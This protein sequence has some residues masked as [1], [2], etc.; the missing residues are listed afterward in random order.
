[1]NITIKV[2]PHSEQRY[3][4]VDDWTFDS[5]GNLNINVSDCGDWKKESCIAVHAIC[6]ALLCFDR[7]IDEPMIAAFDKIYE[8]EREVELH[9]PE[10]EPGNDPAAPYRNEHLF[11]ESLER[12]L[13][14]ELKLDWDSY[15]KTVMNLPYEP[16]R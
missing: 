1:M 15:C 3:D 10:E 13:A 7:G 12:P 16:K 14:K 6:E 2:I 8:Q 4:T 5:E 9:G 11:A